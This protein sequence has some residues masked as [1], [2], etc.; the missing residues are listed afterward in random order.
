CN[1]GVS[2]ALARAYEGFITCS[3]TL[4]QLAVDLY[5]LVETTACH[6]R[7]A[8]VLHIIGPDAGSRGRGTEALLRGSKL[9]GAPRTVSG[10]LGHHWSLMLERPNLLGA[11]QQV[12]VDLKCLQLLAQLR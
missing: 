1:L 4:D 9:G 5:C 11:S 2:Q 10:G 7:T 3:A 12:V 8:Q 6:L